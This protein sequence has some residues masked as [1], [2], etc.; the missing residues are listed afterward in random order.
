MFLYTRIKSSA[1]QMVLVVSVIIV[2]LLLSF[3]SLLF[4]QKRIS[5]KHNNYSESVY[6]N[7]QAFEYAKIAQ[8]PY[9]KT[10]SIRLLSNRAST[11]IVKKQW[12]AFELLAIET[13]NNKEQFIQIALLGE[14]APS[15]RA[16]Y[17]TDNNQQL[18]LVGNT[19]IVGDALLPRLGV[20]SGNISGLTY[21]N[22]KF[23]YGNIGQSEGVM[24]LVINK[25]EM[26]SF[27]KT[28]AEETV[29]FFELKESVS[30]ENSFQNKTFVHQ[31]NGVIDLVNANLIGNIIVES[32]SLIR[33]TASA[34]LHDVVLVAPRIEILNGV[35]GNFQAFA[36]ERII[37][38]NNVQL[39]YPSSLILFND[40]ATGKISI[41]KDTTVKGVVG[42]FSDSEETNYEAQVLL[43]AK[44]S[45][46]GS[47]Y[48]QGNME[49][50]GEVIGSVYTNSFV[51][52]EFGGIYI[53]HIFDGHIN[54]EKLPKQFV[55]FSYGHSLKN[56][57]KWLY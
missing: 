29:D 35:K 20:N 37:V 52:H 4:F 14:K 26:F 10:D 46:Y 34:N 3:I 24:P 39:D 50:R 23:I 13:T 44:A 48:C 49:L 36:T 11:S 1:L 16:I 32:D 25:K 47:V 30:L 5:E 53:N 42:Y 17:L 9:G 19:T 43:E 28:Y 40:K 41:S 54:S 12:G 33:V 7:Q 15:K 57:A 31:N 22:K 51:V 8:I 55:G 2:I 56:I 27:L 45:V 21:Q 38:N 6:A 18:I